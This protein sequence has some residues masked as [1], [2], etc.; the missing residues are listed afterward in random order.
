MFDNVNYAVFLIPVIAGLVGW[1]TNWVAVRM[2]LYP[3]EYKGFGP[4]G[5]QGVVPA[6]SAKLSKNFSRLINEELLSVRELFDGI[7]EDKEAIDRIVG[8]IHERAL[9]EFSEEIA[10]DK[11]AR[12]RDKLREYISQLIEKN[13]R[14]IVEDIIEE[15]KVR[16]PEFIDIEKIVDDAMAEEPGLLGHCMTEVADPEFRFIER[17]GWWFGLIFGLGQ[18]AVWLVY[19]QQWILP[20]AGFLVGYVTNYVALHLI[21][22]PRDPVKIGPL[23]VQGIFIKRRIEAGTAFAR[24]ISDKV[25]TRDNMKGQ[26]NQGDSR[27]RLNNIVSEYV[28]RSLAQY[29][30]DPMVLMLTDKEKLAETKQDVIARI[31]KADLDDDDSPMGKDA[32][33]LFTNQ[34]DRVN[35]Q[36]V[37]SLHSL[38]DDRFSGILRPVFQ[39]DEWKLM[40]AG[41][42]LGTCAGALQATFF[43]GGLF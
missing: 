1:F 33:G 35:E 24:V 22:E 27:E 40:V 10:P 43:F 11:W 32:L 2:T 8:R 20:V 30:K 31:R 37:A 21:F 3:T 15:L 14:Q 34:S 6:N 4:I 19:P 5:W 12:A 9:K 7:G 39:E 28:E 26:L 41:G 25:L 38:D 36:M 17:S 16:A 13:S 42:V 18:M 23:V 29:E